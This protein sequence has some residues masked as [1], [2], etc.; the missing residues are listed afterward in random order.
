MDTIARR[1]EQ[2]YPLPNANHGISL[3]SYY[4]EVV[5]NVRPALLVL[6]AAVGFLLLIACANLA[7]L[8]FAKADGRQREIAVRAALGADRRRIVQHLLTES[9]LLAMTGGALG[10]LIASWGVRAFVAARP[11]S[12]P[13]IDLIAVD[14]RVMIFSAIATIVTGILFGLLPALR[15][16]SANLL[17]SLKE[18]SR[19][20]IGVGWRVRSSLVVVEVA[21][22]LVLLV[23][24]GLTLRSFGRLTSIDPGFKA[25]RV[26][27]LRLTLPDATYPSREAWV[28]FHRELLRRVSTL[29]G[30]EAVGINSAVPL[31][32]GGSESEV[33]AEGQPLPTH[34][35]DATMCLFQAASPDYFS[36]MGIPVLEGRS[37]TDADAGDS[38]L[39]AVVDESLAR[40]L[41][42]NVDPIGRRIAFEFHGHSPADAQPI[43]REIVG[44]VRHVR[45]YGLTTEP[46]NV[47]VYAPFVQLPLWFE[48]RRP[49]M[50]LVA[51]TAL[52][53]EAFAASIRHEVASIDRDIPIYG[54]Q[55]MQSYIEQ[56]TEVPRLSMILLASFG[57]IA[58]VLVVVG[59]YGV[60][61]YLV[62]Q[63]RQEIGVRMAL[64]ATSGDVLRLIV[65]HAMALTAAGLAIGMAAS[66]A[67]TRSLQTLLFG[68]SPHDPATF[69]S[70][71]VLV[72]AIAL[73]A[74]YLPG[75]R[76]T[77]VDPAIALRQ[78]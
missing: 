45:H 22:A 18:A 70:I 50:A 47:Q 9:L 35:Q 12:I 60:L 67:L 30:I 44:V 17:T 2:Q 28:T 31:E 42:L 11:A 39:V 63:R 61:S 58:L 24:A 73:A 77:E 3:T 37:F 6:I 52:E 29:P 72:A 57:T 7:N 76:A 25:E 74:S 69:A 59:I 40:K 41:F 34:D 68:I 27:T 23:G 36:A 49:S 54:I 62:S 5:Q 21:L 65:G 16:S 14:R 55:T 64:G 56:A 43:W 19:G 46:P 10:V 4:E 33:V 8:M 15:A 75:R 32:G 51:R 1:L 48:Q 78:E 38:A 26:V 71:A 66:W 13:R 53:P 20:A